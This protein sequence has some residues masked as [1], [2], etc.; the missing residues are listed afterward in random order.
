MSIAKGHRRRITG[1]FTLIEI[2]VF[3][4]IVSVFYVV[5]AAVSAFSLGVMKTNESK[6]YAAHYAD[7]NIEWLRNEKEADWTTFM[8]RAD[9]TYCFNT[10]SITAWPAAGPCATT[11]TGS[12]ALNSKFN[13]T[14]VLQTTGSNVEVT[15]TVNWLDISNKL[16]SVSVKTIFSQIE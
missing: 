6:I 15:A 16:Q 2:L 5:A 9:K 11:G 3:T 14:I 8:T 7:E 13:R 10:S 12:Y 4:A 1:G